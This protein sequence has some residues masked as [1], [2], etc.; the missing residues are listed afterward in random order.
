MALVGAAAALQSLRCVSALCPFRSRAVQQSSHLEESLCGGG[1]G[2]CLWICL[3]SF[4]DQGSE[5]ERARWA[6]ANRL[7][8]KLKQL[9]LKS[10]L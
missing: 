5:E 4:L 6:F 8:Q 1:L 3:G 9:Y 10:F 2:R 7:A